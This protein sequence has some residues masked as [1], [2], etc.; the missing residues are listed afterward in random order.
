MNEAL[1]RSRPSEGRASVGIGA[2][3]IQSIAQAAEFRLGD[4]D[5]SAVV[6]EPCD[7]VRQ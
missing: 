4:E 7:V 5:R 3:S 1:R 2:Q 6:G